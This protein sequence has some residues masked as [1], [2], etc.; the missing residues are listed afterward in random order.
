MD[1]TSGTV[2]VIFT[3]HILISLILLELLGDG[4]VKAVTLRNY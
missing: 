1:S 2:L 4:F 3:C